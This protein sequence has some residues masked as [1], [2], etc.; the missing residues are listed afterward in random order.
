MLFSSNQG[1]FYHC[2]PENGNEIAIQLKIQ[3]NS[4]SFDGN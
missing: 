4:K 3:K 2:D 1:H